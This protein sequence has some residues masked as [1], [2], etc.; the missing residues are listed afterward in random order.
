LYPAAGRYPD[1]SACP[2][3]QKDAGDPDQENVPEILQELSD[4][5]GVGPD[6]KIAENIAGKAFH[7]ETVVDHIYQVGDQ[8]DGI[9]D[10]V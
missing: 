5:V 7:G 1:L 4:K 10:T 8:Q 3:D 2:C 6:V 9:D